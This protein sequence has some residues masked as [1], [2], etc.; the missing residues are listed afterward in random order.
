M[1]IISI[2]HKKSGQP[3][4]VLDCEVGS[5]YVKRHHGSLADV[6]IDYSS[7]RRAEVKEYLEKRYN[8][9]DK[10]RVFSA[11][12]FTTQ[13]IKSAIKDIA[14]THKV[15]VGSTNY[16]NGILEDDMTFTD[17]MALAF[18]NKRVRDYV[19]KNPEVF[20]EIPPIFNQPR[21]AGVHASAVITTPDCVK[22]EDVECFDV[23]PIRKMDGIL[24]SELSG[25]NLDDLGFLKS[26]CLSIAELERLSAMIEI[27]N[28]EY[29][30]GIS[31]ESIINGDL[32]EPPVYQMIRDGITQGIFQLSGEGITRFIKKMKPDNIN[33]LIAAVAL[34]R[35]GPLESG[36]AQAYID[37][38]NGMVEPEYLWGT[39]DIV[40]DTWGQLIYQEQVSKIAQKIGG[41]TLSD[42]VNLV[43]ALSKKK[44]E[45]V[46]KFKDKYFEGARKNNCPKE[47]A[48][49]IWSIVEDGASYLFN[50]S[51]SVA[52][53][54]TG[55]IGAWIK[56]HY[57]IAFYTVLLKWVDSDKIPTLMNE[58]R[59]LGTAKIVEPD[60]NIS[61]T[62]FVTNY[63]TETIYWSLSRIK[64]LGLKAVQ[65]IVREHEMFGE[66]QSLEDFLMRMF[67]SGNADTRS[68]T[69]RS[70]KQ[71][72]YAGAFDGVENARSPL[73]RYGMLQRAS[74]FLGFEIPEDEIPEERRSKHYYWSKKQIE[75]SGMGSIDYKR[76]YDGLED[77]I[78]YIPY[79][80]LDELM[81]IDMNMGN[82][83][84][85][86]K[87]AFCATV[88]EVSEKR[89]VD[90]ASGEKKRFGKVVLLQN[91]DMMQLTIWNDA[92]LEMKDCFKEGW[93]V[94]GNA[95]V[96]YSDYDGCNTL[97]IDKNFWCKVI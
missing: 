76:I 36:S 69:S 9:D 51:H 20:E 48:E 40:K 71:L 81:K 31:I 35:P 50:Q 96:K 57:P 56:K 26:D 12:T 49:R 93:I 87:F 43:K 23:I 30:A 22:G 86:Q 13:R 17:V 28:R 70:V 65:A 1:K 7:D 85:M 34:F 55:Y 37:C 52:Y 46:R 18:E 94:A 84:P 32:N 6:D 14:R 5:G 10:Q 79:K 11:G 54:L 61:G 42:G 90:R 38:K 92:W 63:K 64:Y 88:S 83:K 97:Q 47:A 67:R 82:W 73:E 68:V 53:G 41:L 66:F 21:S 58:M 3:V 27:C 19:M 8:H 72:I 89:Y 75:V 80:T 25:Y 62:D 15:S 77:R 4:H 78:A 74:A 91:T 16:F 95:R 2:S 29:K 39:Y 33:D 24:V 60:I 45:K 44:I 59:E